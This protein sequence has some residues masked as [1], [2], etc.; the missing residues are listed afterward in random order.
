MSTILVQSISRDATAKRLRGAY[1]QLRGRPR[2]S[3]FTLAE[4][5]IVVAVI[6]LLAVTALS[7]MRSA[8][9]EARKD[10]TRAIIRRIDQLIQ[11]RYQG[12]KTRQLPIARNPFFV[13]GLPGVFGM[14][15]NTP[16]MPERFVDNNN[17]GIFDS[18]DGFAA[19]SNADANRNG[20]YD[21][22]VHL[23]RL[24][25]TR[26]L[27]R[28]E[29]PER[30]S[31][32]FKLI[33]NPPPPPPPP[34]PP[35][36]LTSTPTLT[37]AYWRQYSSTHGNDPSGEF[38]QW[39][40]QFQGAECLYLIVSQIR[41]GDK[42]ATE[43]FAADEIGDVDND[44]MPEILDAWGTPIEFLRWAPGYSVNPPR[45]D[46][47]PFNPAVSLP[48]NASTFQV[49]YPQPTVANP[50]PQSNPPQAPAADTPGDPFDVARVDPHWA[51]MTYDYAPSALVRPFPLVPLIYSAGPDRGFDVY[52]H[53][54]TG[55]TANKDFAYRLTVPPN[56]PY[57]TRYRFLGS[58]NDSILY[59]PGAL[60]DANGN[61]YFE[62]ADNITNHSEDIR[63][64]SQ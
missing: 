60:L 49:F 54:T 41:E 47:A 14:V 48:Y 61:G 12:Y 21:Y 8:V 28:L 57:C 19:F 7:V 50:I 4:L 33:P 3:A 51:S 59:L 40:V 55:G 63:T 64:D 44:G 11:E 18:G 9:E 46:L 17:N 10:R 35:S 15:S 26:E 1:R 16:A 25:A 5:L 29:L 24:M 32:I 31:D 43:S 37:K 56:D 22:G 45:W 52:V 2:I 27:M 23:T 53:T 6:S 38:D 36:F 58:S 34:P 13:F 30:K 20:L 42:R 62:Y 39:S